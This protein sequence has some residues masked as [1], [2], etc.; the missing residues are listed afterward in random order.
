MN[1]G[2]IYRTFNA[3][4]TTATGPQG[5]CD[6]RLS[7]IR[8]SSLASS[9]GVTQFYHGAATPDGQSYVAGTQDNGT[10]LG[11]DGNGEN[12]WTEILGGD[13][14]YV[15]INPNSPNVMYASFQGVAISK[16]V[17][18]GASFNDVSEDNL[19]SGLFIMP[20]LMDRNDPQT[21]FIAGTSL[22]RTSNAAASWQRASAPLGPNY[23]DTVSAM[24]LAPDNSMRLYIGN[25]RGIFRNDRARSSGADSTFVMSTPRSGWVSSIAV[26]PADDDIAY[27]S[28]STVGGS[29]VWR[30][31]EGGES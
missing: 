1:D 22:W 20:Y 19:D 3:K 24:A 16:S 28:Y 18:G 30:T 10:L 26:D 8:W 4:Q 11:T 27:A 5:P 15:S 29:H 9:Y 31:E 23:E 12:G 25:R 2:G 14:A 7:Q 17:D 13:G 21:L 6:P